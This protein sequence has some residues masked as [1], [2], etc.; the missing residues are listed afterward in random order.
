MRKKIGIGQRPGTITQAAVT[1]HGTMT[2]VS[3]DTHSTRLFCCSNMTIMNSLFNSSKVLG[4]ALLTAL[5]VDGVGTVVTWE[6]KTLEQT[7]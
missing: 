1:R 2:L 7:T 3:H 5:E 4:E 6:M